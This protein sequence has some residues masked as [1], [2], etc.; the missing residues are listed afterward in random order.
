MRLS[1][2]HVYLGGGSPLAT[3]GISMFIRG[4]NIISLSACRIN[5]GG[6]GTY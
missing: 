2:V 4:S 3:H 5:E 6:D 1:L